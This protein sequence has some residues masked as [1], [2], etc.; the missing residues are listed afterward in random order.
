MTNA[1][2][3]K[4]LGYDISVELFKSDQISERDKQ[5]QIM[6]P[7]SDSLKNDLDES[8]EHIK[9]RKNLMSYKT[10]RNI[11]KKKYGV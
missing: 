3:I 5:L 8:L 2:L 11:L 10:F 6:F 9:D 4:K 7:I 1:T